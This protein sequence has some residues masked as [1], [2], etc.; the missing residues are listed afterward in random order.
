MAKVLL[1]S[2]LA[3]RSEAQRRRTSL[4]VAVVIR[5]VRLR[6]IH[7][8]HG[9]THV[10]H[11]VPPRWH[12]LV[13]AVQAFSLLE[14]GD[15]VL[16]GEA[17]DGWGAG[18][19]EKE[20]TSASDKQFLL[21]ISHLKKISNL[22]EISRVFLPKGSSVGWSI[23]EQNK[24]AFFSFFFISQIVINKMFC[25]LKDFFFRFCFIM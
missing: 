3:G 5:A 6:H 22:A 18:G 19:G 11:P 4:D 16:G 13:D 10:V 21:S 23:S 1:R 20:C 24:E 25:P 12:A 2:P 9:L 14:A 8:S 7:L 15:L 17:T